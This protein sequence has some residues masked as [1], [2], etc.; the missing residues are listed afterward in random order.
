MDGAGNVYV[1][2]QKNGAAKEIPLATPPSLSFASTGVGSSSDSPQTLLVQ[3]MGNSN[4]MFPIPGS[5]SNPSLSANHTLSNSSTCPQLTPSTS[6]AQTLAPGT[7]TEVI[8]F[9]PVMPSTA[10]G[11]LTFSDNSNNVTNAS[12]TVVLNGTATGA[13][14][15]TAQTI[16]FPQP[17]S[18]AQAETTATLT[19]TASSNLAITYSVV[20]GPATL[21][22]S[23]VTYT[24]GG[25]VVLEADQFGNNICS[26]RPLRCS[27]R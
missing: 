20:S 13:T 9:T 22:G 15:T 11:S 1:A 19:A 18:P 10:A 7:C 12:Q 17:T 2:D 26:P 23:T 24:G 4:L 5:G 14:G 25:T 6:A 3:N 8:S 21:S 27:R 16:T